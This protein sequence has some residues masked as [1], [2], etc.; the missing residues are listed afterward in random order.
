MV[1][2]FVEQ[3]G[4]L[5]QISAE[6]LKGPCHRKPLS[7]GQV[8]ERSFRAAIGR[9]S[10]STSLPRGCPTLRALCEGWDATL[11]TPD[12]FS[13]N[14]PPSGFLRRDKAPGIVQVRSSRSAGSAQAFGRAVEERP[15][16]A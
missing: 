1:P 16:R 10:T 15:F 9:R 13:F 3:F 14:V 7:I 5:A 11:S 12:H 2:M 4:G 6:L 8:E